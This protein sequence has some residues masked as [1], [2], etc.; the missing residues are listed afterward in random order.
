VTAEKQQTSLTEVC[1]ADRVLRLLWHQW[2]THIIWLLGDAGHLTFGVLHRRLNGISR[3][4]L[5][6]RLRRMEADGLI[7][8]RP[9]PGAPPTV[10]YSLTKMGRDV[11]RALRGLQP[12][13]ERWEPPPRR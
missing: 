4:V 7:E 6:Q 5:T 3:K 10:S 2:T 12:V 11:D 8:R 1:S 9:Q 13:V